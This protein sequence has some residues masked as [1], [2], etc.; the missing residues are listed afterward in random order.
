MCILKLSLLILKRGALAITFLFLKVF[1]FLE[2]INRK[3]NKQ[4][5]KDIN[6]V[7]GI[8]FIYNLNQKNPLSSLLKSYNFCTSISA[9]PQLMTSA[10][11]LDALHIYLLFTK[12][13]SCKS[14]HKTENCYVFFV[15][16]FEK[17]IFSGVFCICM[18]QVCIL[19]IYKSILY[20]FVRIVLNTSSIMNLSNLPTSNSEV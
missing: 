19:S 7:I 18:Y 1:F 2:T 17:R 15:S 8:Y 6:T 5:G 20:V 9:G 4:I 16:Y 3:I 12:E 10:M 13:L 14:S 11:V